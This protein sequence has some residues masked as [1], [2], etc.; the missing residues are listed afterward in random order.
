[1]AVTMMATLD[2]LQRAAAARQNLIITHEPTFYNHLDSR[3]ISS[4]KKTIPCWQQSARLF[5]STVGDLEISRSL[6]PPNPDGIEA[7]WPT[8]AWAGKSLGFQQ[9]IPVCGPRNDLEHLAGDLKSRLKI[10]V[11]RVCGDPG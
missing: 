10:R 5:R 3:T 7:E 2:V 11:M 4:K 8:R 1:M 9:P 6:A